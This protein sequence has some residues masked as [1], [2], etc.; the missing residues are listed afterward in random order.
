MSNELAIDISNVTKSYIMYPSS[1]DLVLEVFSFFNFFRRKRQSFDRFTALKSINLKVKKGER[2]GII[3]RNG[4]GKSTLLKLITGNFLPTAGN[5][6]VNGSV[7]ALMQTGLGFHQELSG[8]DNIRASLLYNHLSSE[9]ID[10]AEDDII[11]FCELGNFLDY[12]IKTYS[13]GMLSRLQFACA[14]AI[15]PDILI[16]DEVLGAGDAY[17]SGKCAYRMEKLTNSGCTLLLV[18]HSMTQILQFC[19]KAIWIEHGE[20]VASGKALNIIKAY[21]EYINRLSKSEAGMQAN[22]DETSIHQKKILL[23][24]ILGKVDLAE[25]AISQWSGTYGLKIKKIT[26]LDIN[27]SICSQFNTFD[28][29][30][31]RF[32][33]Y[34]EDSSTY[35]FTAVIVIFT[36]DGRVVTRFISRTQSIKIK[37]NE[38]KSIE[39]YCES[40]LLGNGNY[41]LSVALYKNLDLKN[42]IQSEPYDLL[43]RC[44]KFKVISC[45]RFDPSLIH[46]SAIWRSKEEIENDIMS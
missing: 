25:D 14:T 12:P 16:V 6:K 21:E 31:I 29:L 4:A 41:I 20:I 46:M 8:R 38:S 17:F 35:D 45:D 34:A 42:Q 40:L 37:K 39:L 24:S 9:E 27:N 10:A 22:C 26:L 2:L 13:L 18:S 3:G 19:E 11:E 7:Q 30:I 15:H 23:R 28:P 1:K 44:F 33:Y 5:I 43:S 36:D 32:E